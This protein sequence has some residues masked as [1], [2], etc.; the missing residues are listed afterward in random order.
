[1]IARILLVVAGAFALASCGQQAP[2]GFGQP[3]SPALWTIE[4]PDGQTGWLFGTIHALPDGVEWR[5]QAVDDALAKSG[6]LIVEVADLEDEAGRGEI[7]RQLSASTSQPALS[8]R[9]APEYCGALLAIMADEGTGDA[10]FHHTDTWAAALA[11]S[12]SLSGGNRRN[13][14]DRALI[15]QTPAGE[16]TELEGARRQ[17]EIFDT[18][19][20]S[21]QRDLLTLV[22]SGAERLGTDR[23]RL[24][25]AWYRGDMALIA[26]EQE[27][28]ILADAELREAL[29]TRRNR[30]WTTRIAASLA[31][32]RKPFVAVGAAHIPGPDGLATML[33]ASGLTVTRI[34]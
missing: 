30:A 5:S 2:N 18:L 15:A 31:A 21:E 3:P 11:I 7:F 33:R 6:G 13:G 28:G 8:R 29:L 32:G 10:Q 27:R 34:Q 17:L 22:V 16:I 20:E 26:A 1:M 9:V 4:T 19:P 12:G 24:A 14:V 25:R 23:T